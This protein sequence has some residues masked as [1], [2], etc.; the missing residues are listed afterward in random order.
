MRVHEVHIIATCL[1]AAASQHDALSTP[2]GAMRRPEYAEGRATSNEQ[3]ATS[4]EQ[5]A[6]SNEQPNKLALPSSYHTPPRPAIM[7]NDQRATVWP[8]AKARQRCIVLLGTGLI[9]V[10]CVA[11]GPT[12]QDL[13]RVMNAA[14]EQHTN[15]PS[16]MEDPAE[17]EMLNEADRSRWTGPNLEGS[18]T[19]CQGPHDANFAEAIPVLR[20]LVAMPIEAELR[21][22]LKALRPRCYSYTGFPRQ[23]IIYQ[24]YGHYGQPSA[25]VPGPWRACSAAE[26][27]YNANGMVVGPNEQDRFHKAEIARSKE[28]PALQ[29]PALQAIG[30]AQAA[31][32]TTQPTHK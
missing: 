16:S 10:Q 30:T 28:Q 1:Q 23:I 27:V 26:P 3:R 25:E 13:L 29:H 6:T 5:R 21:E 17:W 12:T 15:M 19:E 14:E 20:T 2:K 9:L 4:N 24:S 32:P 18:G 31:E 11:Q 22:A 7:N 8:L